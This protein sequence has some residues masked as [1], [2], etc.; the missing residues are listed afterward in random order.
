MP[1]PLSPQTIEF[2][3]ELISGGS[4]NDTN[5]PIGIYRSGTKLEKFMRGCNVDFS[6]G[7]Q[8]RVPALTEALIRLNQDD[9]EHAKLT[10]IIES[11]CSQTD[12]INDSDR[13]QKVVETLNIYLAGD[14]FEV[15]NQGVK[16]RLVEGGMSTPVLER[17]S[18]LVNII[19]FDTVKLDL[20]RALS[21][22]KTDPEDAVTAACSTLESVCRSIIVELGNELPNKKDLKSL[23]NAVREPLGLMPGS[24]QIDPRILDDVRKILS[25]LATTVEGIAALR[26]HAGDAHGKTKG[27]KRIDDRIANLAIH[28]SSTAA[29][30][31]IETWHRKY[32]NRALRLHEES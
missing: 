12:F 23:Y 29:L 27:A 26:T 7:G 32:P 13:H 14:G 1:F 19:S 5:P 6:L 21:N 18:G 25:G 10:R 8:S 31:I 3:G 9:T 2:L 20:D 30:F 28:S 17:L 4:G 22:S 15:V 11:A 16:M 24:T